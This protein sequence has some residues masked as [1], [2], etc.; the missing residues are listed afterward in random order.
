[1]VAGQP[2]K[3]VETRARNGQAFC[4]AWVRPSGL[5]VTD[6]F[7]SAI[8]RPSW[9]TLHRRYLEIADRRFPQC[10]FVWV[11]GSDNLVQLPRWRR[12]AADYLHWSRRSRSWRVPA[13]QL[14][15]DNRCSPAF[16]FCLYTGLC[17]GLPSCAA[18]WTILE[19][20]DIE[21]TAIR[22]AHRAIRRSVARSTRLAR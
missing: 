2:A 18:A 17:R 16:C 20:P 15:H 11:M 6:A 3:S 9:D 5:C 21:R 8:S 4:Q 1:M 19:A 12:L 10:A 13:A 7:W 14:L 22:A